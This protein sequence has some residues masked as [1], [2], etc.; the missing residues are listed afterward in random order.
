M[1]YD[2]LDDHDVDNCILH[3]HDD[4]H[5]HTHILYAHDDVSNDEQHVFLSL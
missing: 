4:V 2:P 5:A 1:L 3:A